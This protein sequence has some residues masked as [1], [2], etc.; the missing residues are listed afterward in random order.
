MAA[1]MPYNTPRRFTSIMDDHPSTSPSVIGPILL[2]PAFV[3]HDVETPESL[4]RAVCTT[5]S[6][7]RDWLT[8]TL[9]VMKI[10]TAPA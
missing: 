6:R 8:S 2:I 1:A 7:P 5:S 4:D 3:D 9:S 10:G